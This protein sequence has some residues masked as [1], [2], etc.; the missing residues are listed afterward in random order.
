M[1]DLR[2]ETDYGS[3]RRQLFSF[4]SVTVE[5]NTVSGGTTEFFEVSEDEDIVSS[6]EKIPE[7]RDIPRFARLV[8]IRLNIP[9]GTTDTTLSIYEDESGSNIDQVA[10]IEN[11]DSADSPESFSLSSANGLPFVNQQDENKLYL[12][13]DELSGVNTD[14]E[15]KLIWATVNTKEVSLSAI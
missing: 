8:T 7:D 13:I 1:G 9:S 14:Y 3:F 2:G 12:E 11:L 4:N 6:I 10:R 15:I 5:T